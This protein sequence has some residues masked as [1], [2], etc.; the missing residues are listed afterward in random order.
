LRFGVN[1]PTLSTWW[2]RPVDIT[3][4]LSPALISP[5]ITRT[6]DTTPR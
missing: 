6:S 3:C 5:C 4:S 1:T 2:L